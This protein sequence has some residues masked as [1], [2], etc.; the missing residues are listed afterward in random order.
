MGLGLRLA[1][2]PIAQQRI[3]SRMAARPSIELVAE[4]ASGMLL[5][6]H[7]VRGDLDGANTRPVAQR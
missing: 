7:G 1:R 2:R 6:L 4:P 5:A 3:A